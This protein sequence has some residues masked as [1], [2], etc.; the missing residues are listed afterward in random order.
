MRM[1]NVY[2]LVSLSA[3][4]CL[5]QT[6][7][8]AES[9]AMTDDEG[10]E[11]VEEASQAAWYLSVEQIAGVLIAVDD[12]EIFQGQI[13]VRRAL[14]PAVQAFGAAMIADHTQA[15][16]RVAALLSS[17][18]T[19]PLPGLHSLS[20]VLRGRHDAALLRRLP[21]R[22]FDLAYMEAQ[23]VTHERVLFMLDNQLIPAADGHPILALLTEARA[24][25]AEHL[26][27]AAS[28]RQ[29]LTAL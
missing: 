22:L 18:G 11:A 20:V 29:S 23:I 21:G 5:G 3:L 7:C 26:V 14:D 28:I 12:A 6:G 13:A 10:E 27:L 9:T 16:L 17:L 19:A 8:T 15:R 25:V 2:R 24:M 1:F 4:L